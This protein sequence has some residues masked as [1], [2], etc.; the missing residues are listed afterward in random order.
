MPENGHPFVNP[1]SAEC[2]VAVGNDIV[3]MGN[4]G[5]S[6][7]SKYLAGCKIGGLQGVLSVI[8]L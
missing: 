6:E 8:V 5:A 7:G 3:L 4:E 1:A 2:L